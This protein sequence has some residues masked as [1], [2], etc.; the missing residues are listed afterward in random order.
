MVAVARLE[1]VAVHMRLCTGA[2][3]RPGAHPVAA[4]RAGA[5]PRR[6]DRRAHVRPAEG[7]VEVSHLCR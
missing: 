6:E 1:R 4:T 2:A 5:G 7:Y 3:H